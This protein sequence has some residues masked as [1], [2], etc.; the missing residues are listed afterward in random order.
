MDIICALLLWSTFPEH[1]L[2]QVGIQLPLA[3]TCQQGIVYLVDSFSFDPITLTFVSIGILLALRGACELKALAAGIVLYL[4]YVVSIGGDFMSGRFLTV[5]LLASAVIL[6]RSELSAVG[7]ASIALVLGAFGAISLPATM[8]AGR[9]Y[10]WQGC[11]SSGIADERAFMFRGRGLTTAAPGFFQQ[12][13]W[14]PRPRAV[15]N[16]CGLLGAVGLQAGP[17]THFIDPCG[18]TDPLLARLPM[19]FD[20]AWRVGHFYRRVP[21]G[22][23]ASIWKDENLLIDPVTR[24]YWEVIR[25]ATRGP[26]FSI[27]RLKA[28][29][30]LSLGIVEKPDVNMYRRGTP[31]PLVVDIG[32]LSKEIVAGPGIACDA[33]SNRQFDSA[34]EVRLP[35]PVQVSTI[36]LSLNE[37]DWYVVQYRT[38]DGAYHSLAEFNST[39]VAGMTRHRVKL[40][41]LTAM[42]DRLRITASARDGCY[43]LGHLFV[44]R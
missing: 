39:G 25:K 7:T 9:N 31:P 28:V 42:T 33:P 26:L 5:P 13:D 6:S 14:T 36:D 8:L 20:P 38:Q 40:P 15:V 17:N 44:N 18:L 32:D 2:R 19:R 37:N 35:K 3:E 34:I 16:V 30:R 21:S 4:L 43:S 22:Y 41:V 23:T 11:P 29:T 27:D 24:D 10:S 1:L 12:P